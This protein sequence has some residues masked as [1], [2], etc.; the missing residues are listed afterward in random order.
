MIATTSS[1]VRW[2]ILCRR[3]RA[4]TGSPF[5]SPWRPSSSRIRAR[6]RHGR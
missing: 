4:S 5:G 3:C 2:S 6:R 1:T